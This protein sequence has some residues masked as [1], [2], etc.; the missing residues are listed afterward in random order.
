M[1][2]A[3]CDDEEQFLDLF[4]AYCKKYS[5]QTGLDIR[6]IRFNS[7]ED[8][9]KYYKE[10]RDL[11][12]VFMDIMMDGLDGIETSQELRNLDSKINIVFLTSAERYARFG[13]K[14]KA[15][16]YL[17][18][19]LNYTSFANEL[20]EIIEI[21]RKDEDDYIIVKNDDG[22]FKIS[23]DQIL[24]LETMDRKVLIHTKQQG[25]VICYKSLKACAQ[26]LDERFFRTHLSY[27][28]N[29]SCIRT[30]R[31]FSLILD[32]G[33]IVPI[34]KSRKCNYNSTFARYYGAKI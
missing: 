7:G 2:I 33:D 15:L 26:L 21:I 5:K 31:K 22:I 1:K 12:I 6:L 18:K 9:L 25:D 16:N 8:F 34:S 11:S 3:I 32:N 29:M 17:M 24:Y 30:T 28:V 10:F 4:E 13:Y 20:R 19:P 23:F 27:I 14:V